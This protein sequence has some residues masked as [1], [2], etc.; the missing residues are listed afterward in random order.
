LN[1]EGHVYF[2]IRYSLPVTAEWRAIRYS[3]FKLSR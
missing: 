2:I 1:I 3:I